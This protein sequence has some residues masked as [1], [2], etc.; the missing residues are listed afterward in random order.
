MAEQPVFFNPY[1]TA[2]GAKYLV[3]FLLSFPQNN[4]KIYFLHLFFSP[5]SLTLSAAYNVHPEL[6]ASKNDATN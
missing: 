1:A 6:A 5:S 4:R 2:L 3:V